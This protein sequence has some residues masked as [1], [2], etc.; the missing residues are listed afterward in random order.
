MDSRIARFLSV[1]FH[2]LLLPTGLLAVLMFQAPGTLGLDAFTAKL[3]LSLLI[4]V[5]IGTFGLPALLIYYLYRSG[6]LPD[7]QMQRPQDRRLPYLLTA[8]LY[9]G[10]TLLFG[11]RLPLISTLAP[12]LSVIL[13]ALT[14]SVLLVAL[15]NTYWKISAHGV[16]VG[17]TVGI[18]AGL[19]GR[20]GDDTLF[21]WLL[22]AV[23]LAGAVASA[24]LRLGAHTA[25]QVW[26]GL[27]L[28]LAVGAGTVAALL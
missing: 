3:R 24:R 23:L 26:V 13:S 21:W 4:L 20:S 18:L 8:L 2:P 28:G 10:L 12:A 25:A 11:W 22:G 17:G 5:F 19:L 7:L 1:V 6:L 27:A 14:L 16:G 9:A 15:I